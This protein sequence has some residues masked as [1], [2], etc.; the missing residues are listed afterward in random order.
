MDIFVRDFKAVG[1]GSNYD[2][3]AIQ[4]AIDFCHMKG[5]GRVVLE[6]G[7]DYLSGSIVLKSNV[8]LHLEKGARLVASPNINDY[9][10]PSKGIRDEG[11]DHVGTSGVSLIL[12]FRL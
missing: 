7:H 5:G 2:T 3:E 10:R 12:F 8:D 6:G 11:V 4:R 9:I 1:D